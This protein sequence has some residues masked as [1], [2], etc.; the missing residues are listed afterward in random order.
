MLC[1]V[2]HSQVDEEQPRSL[3]ISVHLGSEATQKHTEGAKGTP[4]TLGTTTELTGI[5]CCITRMI[6]TEWIALLNS[7]GRCSSFA[8]STARAEK[9]ASFASKV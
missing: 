3:S 5:I 9:D 7:G 8:E 1:G 4:K 2:T 6:I